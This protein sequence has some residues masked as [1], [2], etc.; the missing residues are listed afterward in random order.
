MITYRSTHQDTRVTSYSVRNQPVIAQS[1]PGTPGTSPVQAS[2]SKA[3]KLSQILTNVCVGGELV[4]V[5]FKSL[6]V[7][8]G[9]WQTGGEGLRKGAETCKEG[10]EEMVMGLK[11]VCEDGGVVGNEDDDSGGFGFITEE[12]IVRCVRCHM[13]CRTRHGVKWADLWTCLA[14]RKPS[15]RR[16]YMPSLSTV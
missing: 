1:E 13:A 14:W 11:G 6:P 15:D 10:V 16:R 2:S 7:D 9:R 3:G 4:S 5:A 12:D 8:R